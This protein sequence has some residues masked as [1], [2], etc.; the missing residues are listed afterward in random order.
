MIWGLVSLCL[1]KDE[2]NQPRYFISQVQDI[3]QRKEAEEVLKYQQAQLDAIVSNTSDGLLILN[4]AG[5]IRFANPAA[6]KIL[7]Q[8]LEE[9]IDLYFGIPGS[10]STDI[11][12]IFANQPHK[13]VDMKTGKIQWQGESAYIVSIQ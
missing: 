4:Q 1:V 11:S 3:T 13:T 2:N 5:N 7:Q 9:L 12:L 8:P 10:H 6:S